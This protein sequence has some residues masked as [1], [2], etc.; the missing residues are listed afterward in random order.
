MTMQELLLAGIAVLL[1][2]TGTAHAEERL[3]MYV[4]DWYC[5]ADF[6]QPPPPQTFY[7]RGPCLKSPAH[8]LFFSRRGTRSLRDVECKFSQV[9]KIRNNVYWVHGTAKKV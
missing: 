4:E 1:L 6:E 9:K 3:L 2:T 5:R 8:S 7:K